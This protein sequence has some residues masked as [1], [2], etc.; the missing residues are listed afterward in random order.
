MESIPFLSLAPQHASVHHAVTEALKQGF[1]KNWYILGEALEKF[2]DE[3]A[4]FTNVKYCVGVG[5]GYDALSIALRACDVGPG[6]EVILPAHTYVATWHAVSKCGAAIIPVEPDP[7]TL[8]I[9]VSRIE[10]NITKKTKVLLPVHL[11]GHP[12]DMTCLEAI[13]RN[14]SLTIIE[15][16]AQAQ[17]AKWKGKLTGSFGAVN[18]T[19]FYPT[20]NLGALG[21]G[22]A[23]TTNSDALATFARKYRNYGF[24]QKNHCDIEGVNS[25]LDELQAAVLSIKLTYLEKWN[26]ERRDLANQYLERL[27]GIGD[28]QLPVSE[29]EALPVFHLFVIRSSRRDKLKEFLESSQIQ[30]MIHYPIPPHRQKSYASLNFKKKSFPLTEEIADTCLSL[31]I[32]PGMTTTQ[33]DFV[34]DRIA[35]FFSR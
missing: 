29:K 23:I 25:R 13:A 27:H 19:S 1:E 8:Q 9:D 26:Q 7:V 16:N 32:W 10:E 22:G 20:K 15:D 14:H 12:C 34:C 18:A 24:A 2:E 3:Y 31:P 21:D 35:A 17:G 5:N 4:K 6:D 33:I 11:Y 28:I 30:T